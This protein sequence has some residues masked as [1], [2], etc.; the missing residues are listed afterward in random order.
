M[1][2]LARIALLASVI[3]LSACDENSAGFSGR[4]DPGF[5]DPGGGPPPPPP[6]GGVPPPGG[7]IEPRL[8]YQPAAGT[9]LFNLR[10]SGTNL[11]V[12][13]V[14]NEDPFG[15]NLD[16]QN[17]I[18]SYDIGGSTLRQL[19]FEPM[20]SGIDFENF[21]ITD[22]GSHVVFVTRE[23]ITGGNPTNSF[24]IF[25]AAT[26]GSSVTQVTDN[27][28]GF[29][30]DPQ[31]GGNGG[32]AGFVIAF[33]SESDLLGNGD[34]A[35]GNRELFKIDSDGSGLAQL[36]MNNAL[37]EE[38]ALSDDG[39]WITYHSPLDPFG[40][41]P[42]NSREIFV[43][44]INGNGHAQ[45]TDGL[46]DSMDPDISDD[47][48]LIAFTSRADLIPGGNADGSYEMF[49][50]NANGT[51]LVQ[52]TASADNSGTFTSGAPG[53]LE[54]AGFGN[55]LVFGSDADHTG[56]NPNQTHTV[57]WAN[58]DGTQIGQ[59]LREG[60]VPPD[61]DSRAADNP[62]IVNDG[63][64]LLFDS[65]VNYSFDSTGGDDKIFTTVRE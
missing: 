23:D 65:S 61:I 21:D 52:I 53:A 34:N 43:I 51:G 57:F 17:Q 24:N 47:G 42:D 37:P 41:N 60:Y 4:N 58:T 35:V 9:Q 14:S 2:Y 15:T 7:W 13:F 29:V 8:A 33:Y 5:G 64:G 48:A 22:N 49:V 16:N 30:A 45:L 55:Y 11:M 56:D 62:H 18:F 28:L 31:I 3:S 59:P 46:A 25:M 38:L 1:R 44:D 54:I 20:G 19:T 36:T 26:D 12:V 50:A 27:T 63:S 40:A 39:M 10:I 32:G 6:P